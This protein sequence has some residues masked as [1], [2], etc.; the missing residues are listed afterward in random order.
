MYLSRRERGRGGPAAALTGPVTVDG[1]EL[2]ALLEG[3]RRGIRVY[4]P[5][6]YHWAP[7]RGREVLVL[8]AGGQ[9]E[10]PCALGEPMDNAALGLG[11]G[12]VAIAAG[13]AMV[14]LSPGGTVSVTGTFTVNGTVVGPVPGAE[15]GES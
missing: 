15:G 9:G 12:E 11:P 8:K 10:V 7:A 13:D 5:G 4:A 3:E 1:A 14:R 2:G 6:G